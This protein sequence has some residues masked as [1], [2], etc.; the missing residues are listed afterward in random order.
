MA[1]RI[2]AHLHTDRDVLR[3]GGAVRHMVRGLFFAGLIGLAVAATP[4]AGADPRLAEAQADF[5]EATK[6]RD[7]G[8]FQEAAEKAGHAV[9]LWEAA[10]GE[11]HLEVAKG[12]VLAGDA[13]RRQAAFGRAEPL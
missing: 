8:K 5:D 6:L 2:R 13:Y 9:S 11:G 1:G 4:D 10:L 7:A 3:R 12:L